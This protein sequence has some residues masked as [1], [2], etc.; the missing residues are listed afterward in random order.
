[1]DRI[2]IAGP[3][4]TQKEI[5][6]AAD[7]ARNG[8]YDT[9]GDY[10]KRFETAFADYVGTRFAVSLPSCTSAIHLSLL[11]LG[12]GPGDEV[13]LPDITWIAS[14]A[15]VS[16]VG[17]TPVFADVDPE[18]W[19]LCP[20]SLARCVTPKTCAVIPVEIYGGMPNWDK[21]LA[22]T[23]KHGIAVIEDAA[24]AIGSTYRGRQAGSF[25]RT[26]V[27]S[28]HG[29]KTVTTGE[30]GMLV[31]D[32][33]KIYERV[34]FLRDHGRPPGDR[35]FR[36]TEVGHKYKMSALQAALGL[37]Q[38]ERIEELV[39]RKRDIFAQYQDGLRDVPG[40]RL[41][42]EPA[43]TRNSY[44]MSTI[45][46]DSQLGLDK[47]AAMSRLSELGI[48]TRPFFNP[49]SSLEAYAKCPKAAVA[50]TQNQVAYDLSS[51]GVNLP[52]ALMITEADVVRVCAAIRT[53]VNS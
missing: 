20:E 8:W 42:A 7:A 21:L 35:M 13:I 4:I 30:G 32:D 28:F 40:L 33:E 51:R 22:V 39:G 29:S 15:P 18:T 34:M 46:F 3:W 53:M 45:L 10:P 26:G 41:N 12:I 24:E 5:D 2:P 43:N 11:A 38:L 27:F 14:S 37:G 9:A 48:D 16:Y 25:G 52:S 1:M 17:A 36:N 49:L 19:C 44:W 31:T 23:E 6:Y 47:E 50:R